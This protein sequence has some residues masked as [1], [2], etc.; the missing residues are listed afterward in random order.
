MN[1]LPST[2]A[3]TERPSWNPWPYSLAAFLILFGGGMIGFAFLA[4]RHHQ[5]L[6]RPDYYEYEIRYQEQMDRV[7]RTQA[8]DE[9]V[10]I[11]LANNG[12][13]LELQVPA[14]AEGTVQLYRPADARLDRQFPLAVDAAGQQQVELTGLNPGLWKVRMHWRVRGADYYRDAAVI[15]P[16]H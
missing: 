14:G 5:D 13:T 2:T 16:E 15:L 4:V 6:V 8:L 1:P 9:Q 10:R 7:V 11:A 3:L 12:R